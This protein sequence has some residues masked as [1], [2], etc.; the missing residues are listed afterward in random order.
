M[1][2]PCREGNN[3]KGIFTFSFTLDLEPVNN[4]CYEDWSVFTVL[5]YYALI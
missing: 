2:I 4:P 5:S 1:L 3:N